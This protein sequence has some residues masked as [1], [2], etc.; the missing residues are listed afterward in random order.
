[1]KKLNLNKKVIALLDNPNRIF[2][3]AM[4]TY[5]E[6]DTCSHSGAGGGGTCYITCGS[7]ATCGGN[8]CYEGCNSGVACV[9][10]DPVFN[11]NVR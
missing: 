6:G 11:E 1:M 4:I 7:C 2:G 3:G 8:T 9:V 5:T 10:E